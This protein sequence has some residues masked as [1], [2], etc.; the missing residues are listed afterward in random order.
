ML[1]FLEI[2]VCLVWKGLSFSY[3]ICTRVATEEKIDMST[4]TPISIAWQGQGGACKWIGQFR[5][6]P[7][8]RLLIGWFGGQ[9]YPIPA[10]IKT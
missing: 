3:Q 8:N 9:W 7:E 1:D 2:V 5:F 10:R 6:N 4:K